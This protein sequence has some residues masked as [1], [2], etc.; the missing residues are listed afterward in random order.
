MFIFQNGNDT[1]AIHQLKA[2]R[3]VHPKA[4]QAVS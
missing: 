1:S 4:K 2:K 3:E